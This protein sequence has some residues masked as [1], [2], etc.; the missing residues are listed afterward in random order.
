MTRM[1]LASLTTARVGG[2]ARRYLEAETEDELIIAVRAADEAGEPLLIIGGGSNL[3]I[4][5]EG[6][7]GAVIHIASRGLDIREAGDGT[8][9]LRAEAGHPWDEL[10]AYTLSEG[11]S[12]LEALSGIP[13]LAGATPVQ[14]VGAYGAD[15]SQAITSVRAWDRTERTVVEFANADLEFG[16]RDSVL[17][18][19]TKN[20]SPRYVVLTVEFALSKGST[21]AP[22]RYAELARA[23][24]VEI[25]ERADAVDVRREVLR[26][27]AGKGMVLDASDPDTYSTGSFFTNPIVDEE[28][29]AAL[30]A[31]A[32]RYPVAE[33]GKVKL[34]A[35]WLISHAGFRKGFGLA[36]EDGTGGRASLST[37]HTLA[38]TNRGDAA[39]EDLLVVARAVAAGV[40]K[41]F[42][43]RLHPEPLL[44]NC[45]L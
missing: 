27:R 14:N 29:A 35:A 13:G 24:R 28:T 16:Y 26:L 9:V 20:G 23:L 25:G 40:E 30:P 6:F 4:S 33:P 19:S 37:K 17:K 43:I 44:V 42:G 11:Y 2:P 1:P 5:D 18:R 32:P 8:A 45:A 10:V 7:D 38:V 3:L 31:D 15:V 34:S 12:G 39:A 41:A 36:P 22:V 21:S